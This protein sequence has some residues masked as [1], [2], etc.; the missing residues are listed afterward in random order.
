LIAPDAQLHLI[1]FAALV[2]ENNRYLIERYQITYLNSGRDLIRL[3]DPA[4]NPAAPLIL[5]DPNYNLAA[6][7][8]TLVASSRGDAQRSLDLKTLAY[9][10][11]PATALEANGI[12]PLVPNARLF[13]QE[14]ATETVVKQSAN[15]KILH[16]A[17]H[18][19]FL[20]NNL[21]DKPA[22]PGRSQPL[23]VENPLLRAG[24]ALAGFNVRNRDN[25]DDGVLTAFDVTQL[26]LRATQLVVLS[27]CDTGLGQVANGEGVYGLRRAFTLAGAQSLLMSLWKVDDVGTKDMMIRYYQAL[28]KGQGRGEA[29]RQVQLDMISEKLK[30]EKGGDYQ[31]PY[32]WA[33]FI[34]LG[35]WTPL[36]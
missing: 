30:S 17:T 12:V 7:P 18:G 26:D 32:Y 13:T 6:V 11:L 25:G 5:A 29:L 15:P 2:D 34:P 8:D 36:P 33:A 19:F 20:E 4:V 22:A 16:L 10:S 1:P 21:P 9:G 24:L 27:A 35:D 31:H 28:E 14:Q 3:K 23:N